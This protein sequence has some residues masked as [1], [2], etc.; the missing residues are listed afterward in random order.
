MRKSWLYAL[1]LLSAMVIPMF[2]IDGA[3]GAE[4]TLDDD[5]YSISVDPEDPDRGILEIHGEFDPDLEFG[6]R[7]YVTLSSV[8]RELKDGKAT[9][10]I[11]YSEIEWDDSALASAPRTFD[12]NDGA[13]AFTVYLDPERQGLD[14]GEN[15]I[16]PI[17]L[18][19]DF[20]GSL[21]VTAT[22]EGFGT[23]DG[24][25]EARATIYP[26]P[27]HLINLT[28]PN[29]PV[30]LEAT[31][32]LIY[33]LTVKNIGNL[34]EMVYI[35]IPLLDDLRDLDFDAELETDTFE[36]MIPGQT[37]NSNLSIK[38]PRE[39]TKNYSFVLRITAYTLAEDPT[40]LEPAS[41]KEIRIDL[42]LIKS[43]VQVP[44]VDTDDEPDDDDPQP[45]IN[46]GKDPVFLTDDTPGWLVVIILGFIIL[47]VI[48]II[49]AIR[50]GGDG[51]EG[52]DDMDDAHSSMVRI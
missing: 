32:R 7:I 29:D 34:E 6:E 28:T 4:A 52:N 16:Y 49:F 31:D 20:E 26:E 37:L 15:E 1:V 24:T 40:T 48:I 23:P 51:D 13:E 35:E 2:A 17:G 22:Y 43:K 14:M 45:D 10:N 11:W 50:R 30:T 3:D 27:Y 25:A 9:G 39:I 44:D 12:S 8:V 38:A 21:V 19:L 36:N 46:P 5:E 42:D 18:Q 41:L 33:T 47:I